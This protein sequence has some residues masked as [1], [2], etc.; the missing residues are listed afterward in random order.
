M[1]LG[2]VVSVPI[3]VFILIYIVN[4]SDSRYTWDD[5]DL[6]GDGMVT[7]TEAEYVG[8]SG[9]REIVVDGKKCF[10]YFAYK[11]GLPIKT[12]CEE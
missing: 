4:L 5:M 6:N 10:E 7:F 12:V 2:V 8:S 11:D 1:I 3:A 9:V